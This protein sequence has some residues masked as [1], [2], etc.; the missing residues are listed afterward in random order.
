VILYDVI[1]VEGLDTP[2][3]MKQRLQTMTR[4]VDEVTLN[5]V[6]SVLAGAKNC[7]EGI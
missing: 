6:K 2:E 7:M 5:P 3:L 1:P 4:F